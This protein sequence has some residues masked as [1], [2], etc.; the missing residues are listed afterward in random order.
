MFGT[1]AR[2]YP[3]M[4]AWVEIEA[5]DVALRDRGYVAFSSLGKGL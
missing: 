1:S 3:T 2:T 5:I 4:H